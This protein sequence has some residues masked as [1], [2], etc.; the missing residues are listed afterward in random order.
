MAVEVFGLMQF[1]YSSCGVLGELYEVFMRYLQIT[2]SEELG[3]LSLPDLHPEAAQSV[4]H[5]P[6]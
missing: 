4:L 3:A 2:H 6:T 1:V 5:V